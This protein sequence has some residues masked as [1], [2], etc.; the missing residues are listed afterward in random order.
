MRNHLFNIFLIAVMVLSNACSFNKTK[1][2]FEIGVSQCSDDAWRHTMNKEILR[3]ASFYTEMQVRIK[4]AYDSN[5][6]QIRDIESFISARVDLIIVSPNEAAPLTPVIEKAMLQGIPVILVDRKTTS[7][8]YTAFVGADNYQI[9]VEVGNYIA[10]ALNQQGNIIEIRG[11]KGS[12]PE[13]ER[14]QGFMDAISNKDNLKVIYSAHADWFRKDAKERMKEMVELGFEADLV[15]AHNDE[16]GLGAYDALQTQSHTKKPLIIGIDALSTADGGIQQ[17]INGVLDASFIYPT[18]GEKAIQLA[19]NILHHKAFEKENILST[20]V[21]DKTNARVIKL[22]TDQ[23]HQHQHRIEQLNEVIDRSLAEYT[24]QRTFLFISLLV[25][26][27][28][29]FLLMLL[30][31]MIRQKNKANKLLESQNIEIKKQK[32]V[33]SEQRDQ[34]ISLSKNIED[35]TQSKLVFFTNISHEFRTPLTLLHGPLESIIKNENLSKEGSRLTKLMRKNIQVLMKLIDQITEFRRYETGKMQLNATLSD[36]KT[37]VTEIYN[38]FYEL[39]RKR[40]IRFEMQATADDFIVWFDSDK[41]EKT[42]YNL[43]SNAF[44]FTSENGRITIHLS[45]HIIEHE[46]YARIQIID[47]GKGISEEDLSLIFNRYYKVNRMTSGS[48]IGLELSKALVELHNGT[49]E[50]DSKEDKGSTFTV[51]IPYKQSDIKLTDEYPNLKI[52]IED[53]QDEV[54]ILES[55]VDFEIDEG[56]KSSKPLVL[57]VDDNSDIRV[58]L[59]SLLQDSFEVIEADNGQSGL[60]KAKKFVPELI[61][62]D[63]MMDVMDGFELCQHVKEDISTSHI[64]VM[65]LTAFA[66]DEQ[67]VIGFESGADAYIPKPFN[68]DILKIRV[69]KIIENREKIKSYFQQNLTFGDKKESIAE[70]DKTFIDK[71][72]KI[73][74]D[75]IIETDLN[76]DEI[77]QRLGLSR[78]QLYRKIKSLTNYA[79]NELIRIIRLKAA[80]QYILQSEKTVSEIAYDTGFSSPSYFTKCFK[81][82]FN[83][84]PTEYIK[85]MRR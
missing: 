31:R 2:V 14:H 37:F 45:A 36:L 44:K 50:V 25:L 11:L 22:Q 49:I 33:L 42:L 62:S 43:L 15:F 48:G 47:D 26:L 80:E 54:N 4:T 63:V 29:V 72:R 9:G 21:I 5:Q 30:M 46:K 53:K 83:E 24:T 10:N 67:K 18:G 79:P 85:R 23:V 65:L 19:Y 61:I 66:Q 56:S 84:N 27:L 35:S 39:S 38:S 55:N 57:I 64:P 17:V 1:A 28:F 8:N 82:Y 20:A 41:M 3:E 68:E 51:T 69:R 59:K 73:V 78:V 12:T 60:F 76:V 74:E 81:E 71:F 7:G 40:R 16:M 34:L 70:I 75:N 6:K 58:Y 77:G 13:I 52:S 32:E